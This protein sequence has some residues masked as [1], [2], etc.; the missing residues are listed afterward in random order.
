V[1]INRFFFF[2]LMVFS[3]RT[4]SLF[5]FSSPPLYAASIGDQLRNPECGWLRIDNVDPMF[6]YTGPWTSGSHSSWYNDTF[7]YA[8]QSAS[9]SE[10]SFSFTGSKLRIL[11]KTDNATWRASDVSITIDGVSETYSEVGPSAFK[12]KERNVFIRQSK[13]QQPKR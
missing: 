1:T 4:L 13:S 2:M 8:S 6:T 11:S 9:T 12:E 7:K 10:V 3:F 5:F